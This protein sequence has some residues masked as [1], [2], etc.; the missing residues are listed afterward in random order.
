MSLS[1]IRIVTETA[2]R[3]TPQALEEARKPVHLA[4]HAPGDIYG[5][6]QI[7]ALEKEKVFMQD[8]LCVGREEEIEKPGDYMTHSVMGEP[9]VI[10]RNESGK[11]NAFYNQCRHRG[12]EVAEGA[13]NTRRFKCPY[14]AWTYNL[15]G[16]LVGAAFMDDTVG[17][18]PKTCR[19]KQLRCETWYGWIY[20]SF[21]AEIGP[22]SEHVSFLEEAFGE[23]RQQD[24]GL[25]YKFTLEMN[26]NWKLVYENQLDNYHVGVLH[27]KTV[28]RHQ[29]SAHRDFR[30]RP[31]GRLSVHYGARPATPDGVSLFGKMPW[32]QD[33]PDDFARTG[34]LPPNMTILSRCDMYR[35][36]VHWPLAPNR[37]RSYGYFLLPKEKL[38]DPQLQDKMGVYVEYLNKVLNEDRS[39]VESLQRN[40]LTRGYEP[41]RFST[42][43][44]S[45]HHLMNYHLQ[46]IFGAAAGGSEK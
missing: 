10:A 19:L 20:V 15:D 43:E 13:G 40:L 28:G 25:A 41:G 8:W 12:V 6:E 38:G 2:S 37:T 39:M 27:A 1:N 4:S 24:C 5:S 18:D 31:N 26:C 14:H 7:F 21:N 22:L 36:F 29:S 33:Q 34:F 23:L 3:V 42:K 32:M 46:R 44:T 17:F 45:I 16:Q 11:V 9:I 35:P 30:P